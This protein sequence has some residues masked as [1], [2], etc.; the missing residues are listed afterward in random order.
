MAASLL[1]A[2]LALSRWQEPQATFQTFQLPI[3]LTAAL[4]AKPQEMKAEKG[5]DRKA[6]LSYGDDA[7]YFVSDSPVDKQAQK[8]LTP[9]QQIAAYIFGSL[10]DDKDKHL[11]KYSDALMDGW[12]GVEFTIEDKNLGDTIFSRCFAINGHLIEYGAIYAAGG[13]QPAGLAPFLASIKQSGTPKYGPVTSTNFGFTHVEP[14]G[15]PFSVEVPGDVKDESVDLSKDD[16]KMTL[17]R[18]EYARDM[19]TFDF[20]YLDLPDGTDGSIPADVVEELRNKA[21]DSILQNL[22]ATKDSSTTEERD[23]NDWLTARFNI[24]GVGYGRADVLYFKGRVYS[25][26]AVGPEPWQDS[27]EFK[28]FFDSF[29]VKN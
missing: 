7:V 14:D 21:L 12:P 16:L 26:V 8:D 23:G 24:Q 1:I 22:G 29:E 3:G 5:E 4:P 11:V 6:F 25:L 28:R 18:F 10:V 13:E 19:R 15:V 27:S 2:A 17:H 9:D 20:T